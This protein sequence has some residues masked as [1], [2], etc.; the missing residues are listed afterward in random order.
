M[1]GYWNFKGP[2]PASSF[3]FFILPTVKFHYSPGLTTEINAKSVMIFAGDFAPGPTRSFLH[4][5]DPPD[6]PYFPKS[7]PLGDAPKNLSFIHHH[8]AGQNL[9][10]VFEK[11]R[12]QRSGGP[13]EKDKFSLRAA[14]KVFQ[15]VV[16]KRCASNTDNIAAGKNFLRFF[17]MEISFSGPLLEDP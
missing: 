13:N 14:Q 17:R 9:N 12:S 6:P 16:D 8:G 7:G 15:S 1:I 10:T 4:Q 2:S 11:K 5:G 3:L